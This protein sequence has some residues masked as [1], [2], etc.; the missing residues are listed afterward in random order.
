[1]NVSWLGEL[2]SVLWWVE[3][4]L[5]SP[6]CNMFSSVFWG[7]YVFVMAL[8]NPFFNVHGCVPIFWRISI[9]FHALELPGSWVELVFSVGMETFV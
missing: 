4:D 7:V 5:L 8:G 3:L 9:V 2:V 1:M 6:K